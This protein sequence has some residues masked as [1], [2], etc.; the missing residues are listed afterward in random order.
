MLALL[1]AGGVL[2]TSFYTRLAELDMSSTGDGLAILLY[3]TCKGT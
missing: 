3:H 1:Q 2:T